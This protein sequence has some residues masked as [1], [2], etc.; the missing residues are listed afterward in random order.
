MAAT[1]R[2]TIEFRWPTQVSADIMEKY[3]QTYC[4]GSYLAES[5]CA[6]YH[7]NWKH[8]KALDLV[9]NPYWHARTYLRHFG[10][11]L[12]SF[13]C[14]RVL[15]SGTADDGLLSL[16]SVPVSCM[17]DPRR[18]RFT[19]MDVCPTPL[20][21]C[22][23]FAEASGLNVNTLQGDAR[24]L[25]CD[26]GSVDVIATD[27]FLTRFSDSDKRAVVRE[28]F[29]V[30]GPGGIVLTTARVENDKPT[31]Y[32]SAPAMASYA[33]RVSYALRAAARAKRHGDPPLVTARRAL[34]YSSNMKSR[35]FKSEAEV[36]SLFEQNGMKAF[37]SQG[38]A[39]LQ[40]AEPRHYQFVVAYKP[41]AAG[42][43]MT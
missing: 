29:R 5:G 15:I 33:Q 38:P 34:V 1:S 30:L 17:D 12:S 9:S 2:R 8:L 22:H 42:G 6:W 7:G 4:R 27:A 24:H 23:D 10:R 31:R 37:L 43:I 25:P 13:V 16:L 41:G 36:A 35:P 14:T 28:W 26:D 20:H 32:F 11:A 39:G 3:A 18:V 19:V 21:V 40:E